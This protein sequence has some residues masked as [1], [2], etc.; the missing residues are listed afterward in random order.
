M[1]ILLDKY[2]ILY[3]KGIAIGDQFCMSA[4]LPLIYNTYNRKIIVFTVYPE[5]FKNN[6][7][8]EK[9]YNYRTCPWE[10][11]AIFAKIKITNHKY[12]H[13][14]YYNWQLPDPRRLKLIQWFS[15]GLPFDTSNC[16]PELYVDKEEENELNNKI[17]LPNKYYV[18]HSQ[19]KKKNYNKDY[20]LDRIQYIVDKTSHINWVQ[21]G[22]NDDSKLSGDNVY[23]ICGLLSLRELCVVI[24]NAKT[25]LCMEGLL[26]HIAASFNVK[27]L[28]VTSDYVYPE[29][30]AYENVTHI[31]R[32]NRHND[33]C[34]KCNQWLCSCKYTEKYKWAKDIDPDSIVKLLI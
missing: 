3:R 2:F 31:T 10:M 9:V 25:I 23:N 30:T 24:K 22:V 18:I 34:S 5:L 4:I 14:F 7:Y 6:P 26:V 21:V 27:C 1:E 33:V 12:I 11:K 16:K 13:K 19:G 15:I 8:I 32:K 29:L 20:G 28:C 17:K